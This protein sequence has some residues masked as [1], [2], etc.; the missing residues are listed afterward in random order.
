[1]SAWDG[2]SSLL[3]TFSKVEGRWKL[4][5]SFLVF[6]GLF[7]SAWFLFPKRQ[8]TELRNLT[9][10]L[11][12]IQKIEEL[13]GNDPKIEDSVKAESIQ[14]LEAQKDLRDSKWMYK[15]DFNLM[16]FL[17]SSG[18][19]ALYIKFIFA[20]AP[21]FSLGVCMFFVTRADA[22]KKRSDVLS[23]AMLLAVFSLVPATFIPMYEKKWV[24]FVLIHTF[25]WTV[26]I[27]L[28]LLGLFF[29]KRNTRKTT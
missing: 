8:E 28:G 11:E 5:L 16:E 1:M 20:I 27:S 22:A 10:Q 29:I 25:T 17:S 3:D 24:T 26:F 6:S 13:S 4:L 14:I 15:P 19:V 7:F 12:N 9:I 23:G 2:I 21:Y 18:M